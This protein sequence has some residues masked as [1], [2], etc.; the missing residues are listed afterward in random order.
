MFQ[1]RIM[2]VES[3]IGLLIGIDD[4]MLLCKRLYQTIYII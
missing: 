3:G 4:Y 1:I 2:A